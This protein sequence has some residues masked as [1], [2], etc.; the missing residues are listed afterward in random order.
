MPAAVEVVLPMRS[1][2]N[3]WLY[4]GLA[5]LAGAGIAAAIPFGIVA[6]VLSSL[7]VTPLVVGLVLRVV[8]GR[9]ERA[10]AALLAGDAVLQWQYPEAQWR[11]HVAAER[12][13]VRRFGLLLVGLGMLAGFG[14][15][16]GIAEDDGGIAGSR[17]LAWVLPPLGG[18]LL[19][20]VIAAVV[21]AH[22]RARFDRMERSLGVFCLGLRGMY[23]TGSYWPWND[24]G[25]D[26]R[27]VEL[28]A[29]GMLFHF[30][31][32]EG[33]Q[34]SVRVPIAPGH[35]ATARAWVE[36]VNGR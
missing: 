2:A 30:A 31:V 17:A 4:T 7:G 34:Q 32:G 6:L 20:W 16:A 1:Q 23:L 5:L 10:A 27:G 18:A 13:A 26:L 33:G 24:I 19:G 15:A 12:H 28:G 8:A 22:Q 11:A 29:K 14:A 9:H 3:T 21:Q 25:V 36:R 35:E